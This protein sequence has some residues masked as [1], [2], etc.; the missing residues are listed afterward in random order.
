MH[1]VDSQFGVSSP[2]KK[3]LQLKWPNKSSD[4]DGDSDSDDDDDDEKQIDSR[5]GVKRGGERGGE[6]GIKGDEA[7]KKLLQLSS[8]SVTIN[9]YKLWPKSLIKIYDVTCGCRL[10]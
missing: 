3:D 2:A 8:D 9:C 6:R 10:K 5:R 1:K 7:K 4:S